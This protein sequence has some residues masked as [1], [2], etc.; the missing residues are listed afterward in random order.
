MMVP[1]GFYGKESIHPHFTTAEYKRSPQGRA[2]RARE[3]AIEQWFVKV[4]QGITKGAK[5]VRGITK[6]PF[7]PYI[8]N[9]K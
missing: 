1:R 7:H 5:I 8:K 6:R 4:W 2:D 3:K 9:N